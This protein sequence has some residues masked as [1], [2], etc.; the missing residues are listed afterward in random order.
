MRRHSRIKINSTL[1]ES[2]GGKSAT[3]HPGIQVL[4]I[5]RSSR[6]PWFGR[7]GAVKSNGYQFHQIDVT[8]EKYKITASSTAYQISVEEFCSVDKPTFRNR[9][10]IRYD[11]V[12]PL[13]R[14]QPKQVP[15]GQLDCNS[16]WPKCH[17]K[18]VFG[19]RQSWFPTLN[20]LTGSINVSLATFYILFTIV[21][22]ALAIVSIRTDTAFRRPNKTET[23]A[24]KNRNRCIFP[25]PN[26]FD[27]LWQVYLLRFILPNRQPTIYLLS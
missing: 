20:D 6:C 19:N 16:I 2:E 22:F 27:K 12:S 5:Q 24:L 1:N 15:D 21:L 3:K 11:K 18:L 13:T 25:F 17:L 7:G 14:R 4:S 8:R 23:G 10:V 9:S 26:K